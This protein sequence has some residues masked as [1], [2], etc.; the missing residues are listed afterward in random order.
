MCF[1]QKTG[2]GDCITNRDGNIGK[3]DLIQ[4]A[5]DLQASLLRLDPTRQGLFRLQNRPSTQNPLTVLT[6]S[7]FPEVERENGAEHGEVSLTD[8]WVTIDVVKLLLSSENVTLVNPQRLM[9]R[10]EGRPWP[11]PWR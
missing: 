6:F 3:I 7:D 10:P 11:A 8:V 9:T 4:I 1:P 2:W 5:A